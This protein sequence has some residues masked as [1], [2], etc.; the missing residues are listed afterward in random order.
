MLL[1]VFLTLIGLALGVNI[2]LN[3]LKNALP[4]LR[5]SGGLTDAIMRG[6]GTTFCMGL[7]GALA[8]IILNG[9]LDWAY[10][11]LI[12]TSAGF[13]VDI[14]T[15]LRGSFSPQGA[16]AVSFGAMFGAIISFFMGLNIV[17]FVWRSGLSQLRAAHTDAKASVTGAIWKSAL[18]IIGITLI[19]TLAGLFIG[20]TYNWFFKTFA[21]E[22]GGLA[23][24]ILKAFRSALTPQ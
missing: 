3:T 9:L 19:G 14:V 4:Q 17:L 21:D 15:A 6:I 13:L 5:T 24:D 11:S 22:T 1:T 10:K 12:D 18:V 20:G 16:S 8:G 2:V 23:I 7:I